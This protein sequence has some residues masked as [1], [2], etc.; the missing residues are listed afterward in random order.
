MPLS[1]PAQI[2][3]SSGPSFP[4]VLSG[5][6]ESMFAAIH[7]T[8]I[9]DC[10][11]TRQFDSK[12]E[13]AQH[14]APL[15]SDGEMVLE[16]GDRR[17]PILANIQQDAVRIGE[18]VLAKRAGFHIFD[19]AA[20]LRAAADFFRRGIRMRNADGFQ[21]LFGLFHALH[22]ETDVV[23]AL[24]QAAVIAVMAAPNN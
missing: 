7:L 21:I 19:K 10:R 1:S 5:N 16:K 9:S 18:R 22:F 13:R 23:K 17:S 15:H 20:P 12:K 24:A 6:P 8:S 14:A 3:A 2:Y 11:A 4:Q